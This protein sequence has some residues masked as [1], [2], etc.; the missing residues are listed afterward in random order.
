MCQPAPTAS[1]RASASRVSIHRAGG[2]QSAAP[3]AWT[4]TPSIPRPVLPRSPHT[5]SHQHKSDVSH[6]RV[7]GSSFRASLMD[8]FRLVIKREPMGT[9]QLAAVLQAVCSAD[10]CTGRYSLAGNG[11]TSTGPWCTKSLV[12]SAVLRL[13][14]ASRPLAAR[15]GQRWAAWVWAGKK[16]GALEKLPCGSTATQVDKGHRSQ[17]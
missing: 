2:K 15:K 5:S 14:A 9:Q 8:A 4:P 6:G 17:V 13:H 3:G 7:G 10:R 11:S 16:R 12:G 1:P